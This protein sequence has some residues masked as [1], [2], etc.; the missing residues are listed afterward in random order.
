M[1]ILYRIHEYLIS[2]CTLTLTLTLTLGTADFGM[3][4]I[5][6]NPAI[7]GN[8]QHAS[9]IWAMQAFG[10]STAIVASGACGIALGVGH[11]MG[12][13]SVCGSSLLLMLILYDF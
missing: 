9:W 6:S 3:A 4:K 8:M 2:Y 7:R 12:V 11:Y 5:T 13:G 1:S 10:L